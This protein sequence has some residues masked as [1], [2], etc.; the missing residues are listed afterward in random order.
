MNACLNCM[1]LGLG[2]ASMS[3]QRYRGIFHV[4]Y[5]AEQIAA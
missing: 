5:I 1:E 4:Y 2:N 3:C